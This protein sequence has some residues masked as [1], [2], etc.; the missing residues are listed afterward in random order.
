MTDI[1]HQDAP[2]SSP[3][4]PHE[5][6]RTI[7]LNQVSWG[8][9]L[10]GAVVALVVQLILSLLGIGIGA[11]IV[12]L[13]A[14]AADNPPP[15]EFS[16][17]AGV[18][19]ALSVIIASLAGGYAAGRLAGRPKET[20][21]G[22][23]GLTAW[24]LTTLIVFWF[25]MSGV[26]SIIGGAYRTVVDLTGAV[27]SVAG[28]ALPTVAL[29]GPDPFASIEQA[30]RGATGDNEPAALRDAAVSALRAALTGDP[31]QAQEARERAAQALAQA[32]N[33]SVDQARR[34]VQEYEQRYQQAVETA[35]RTVAAARKAVATAALFGALT[36]IIGAVAAW[37]GGWLSAVQ[38][39]LTR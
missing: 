19:W 38:P 34:Q 21:A 7:L 8:A 25:L 33:I 11:A 39:T 2:H 35:R 1:R 16:I 20:T 14:G 31:D 28:S 29:R 36:L 22:W 37:L 15:R 5:D 24:A 17:G 13:A 4:T 26:G 9:V 32:Q 30:I 18:W 6:V 27:T 3:V 12:D 10:A 23:H